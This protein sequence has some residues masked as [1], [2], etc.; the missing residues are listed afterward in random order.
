MNIY[1]SHYYPCYYLLLT[2]V[3]DAD[4][5]QATQT[6]NTFRQS[7][8]FFSFCKPSGKGGGTSLCY[9]KATTVLCIFFITFQLKLINS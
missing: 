6:I 9:M 8:D 5:L 2:A 1:A 3:L 4:I 7:R